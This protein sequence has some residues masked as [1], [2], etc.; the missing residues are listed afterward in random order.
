MTTTAQ[1]TPGPAAYVTISVDDGHPTDLR[2][3]ELLN[4]HGLPATFYVPARNPE[5]AVLPPAQ[6]RQIGE[7]F[8][9]GGH[10]MNHVPLNSVSDERVWLEISEGKSWL[11]DLLGKP[12]LSFCYP[13][14][15]HSARIADMVKR[16][17]FVGGR[18]CFLNRNDFPENPFIW[19]VSTQA[20]NHSKAI[21]VRHALLEGNFQGALNY[22]TTYKSATDWAEHF[23]YALERV[24]T[25]GGIAHLYLHSWEID[26]NGDWQKL[27]SVLELI[28]Q[29]SLRKVTNGQ[30]FSVWQSQ[31]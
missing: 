3:A 18:T 26:Q 31:H 10:T 15:K 9:L 29:S 17:G 8:E 20:H 19:G 30:L 23:R 2:T 22:L 1:T 21:Q 4:K 12:A 6:L 25:E 24:Q 27:D 14:G 13:R 5:R 16:A 11:D 28:A 7:Q